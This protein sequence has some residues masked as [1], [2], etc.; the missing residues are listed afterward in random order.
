MSKNISML[1]KIG[2][3]ILIFLFLWLIFRTDNGIDEILD[4]IIE[5]VRV[6]APQGEYV[7]IEDALIMAEALKNDINDGSN[8]EI[9]DD[10]NEEIHDDIIIYRLTEMA[11][12]DPDAH[13]TY[14]DFVELTAKI[15]II[16]NEQFSGKYQPGHYFLLADWKAYQN[17]VVEIYNK[18][19]ETDYIEEITISILGIGEDVS[20][21]AGNALAADELITSD[22]E[23][24]T[25]KSSLFKTAS[26]Q[27]VRALKKADELLVLTEMV[28]EDM[29]LNNV[30]FLGEDDERLGFFYRDYEFI[31]RREKSLLEMA[32]NLL[33]ELIDNFAAFE[34]IKEQLADLNFAGGHLR[35][36]NFK[37]DVIS[38]KLLAVDDQSI[39]IEGQ[40]V[41]DISPDW[42]IYRLYERMKSMVANE[43]AI[44]Y[45]FT[46]FVLED[47]EI[48]GALMVRKEAMEYI[49]VA[50]RT[51]QFAG[52]YHQEMKLSADVDYTVTHGAYN[53][54][55]ALDF[56]AG[57]TLVFDLESELLND[58]SVII[59]P[60]AGTGRITLHSLNRSQGIPAYRG[61]IEI[62]KTADGLSLVNEVLL[63][64]YL[65][66]VVPSEMPASY[67]LEA[68]KAQAICART[69]ADRF[70]RRS[71]LPALGAHVDD[72]VGYQVYNNIAE[73]MNTTKAV[74]ETAGLKLFYED[75]PAGTYYYSTSSGNATIPEIWKSTNPPDSPY[76]QAAIIGDD[77]FLLSE[78]LALNPNLLSDEDIF[79]EFI[80]SIRDT[81]YEKDE[82]WYRWEFEVPEIKNEKIAENMKRRFDRNQRLVL[83]LEKGEF[84]SKPIGDIGAVTN[85][86]C[87]KRLPGGV[88]DELIIETTKNTYKIIAEN[89]IRYVLNDDGYKVKRQDL[90]EVNSPNL[91]PSA[92]MIIETDI[93][94]GLVTG[95]KI[96]G[97]GYGHGV[98]MSQNGA[99]ALGLRGY[100]FDEILAVFYI[101]CEIREG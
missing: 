86:Y 59:T 96:F 62:S 14:E 4:E 88:M 43:L 22:L 57:E 9:H 40:G 70:L 101:G 25:F 38:G 74:K 29:V 18:I 92:F 79:A 54:R 19:T 76:L 50:V 7:R 89:T 30:F 99:R 1:I 60:K 16:I 85:I 91:L 63:E 97:G 65:Y 61:S 95:Y 56:E 69:Y 100:N 33:D 84:L 78:S 55:K 21:F 52:L 93:K 75:N 58:G 47:G 82:A 81:D 72:S 39:T 26:Y 11:K 73:H 44:G 23:R 5:D 17:E 42:Q 98:G 71:G 36:I 83:T 41:F 77:R 28:N 64:E 2:L 80:T 45:D 15:D 37:N 12:N 68:L 6:P 51:A 49:R 35:E 46:D 87:E 3:I 31:Y 24:L 94:N 53:E 20:D 13:L 90:S 34:I 67:P 8:E 48:C 27:T 66:S 32:E 10:I